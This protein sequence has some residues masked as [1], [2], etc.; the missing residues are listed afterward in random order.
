MTTFEDLRMADLV[1]KFER[2]IGCIYQTRNLSGFQRAGELL[3]S[4]Y[5]FHLTADQSFIGVEEFLKNLYS[6][7]NYAALICNEAIKKH[8]LGK[9]DGELLYECLEIMLKCCREILS[10]LSGG[11]TSTDG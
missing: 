6:S 9:K 7:F 2:E 3:Q 4:V 11:Q 10:R 1:K 5:N 8:T